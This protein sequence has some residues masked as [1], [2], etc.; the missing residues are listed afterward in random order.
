[1]FLDPCFC[2]DDIKNQSVLVKELFDGVRGSFPAQGYIDCGRGKNMPSSYSICFLL[3]CA[4]MRFAFGD[5]V[6]GDT[7]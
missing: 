3:I 1:M 5:K 6:A 2:R 7:Q 4:Y